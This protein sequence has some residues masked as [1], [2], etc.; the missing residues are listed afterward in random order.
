MQPHVLLKNLAHS[1]PV[2]SPSHSPYPPRKAK[3]AAKMD[4]SPDDFQSYV[5]SL[6]DRKRQSSSAGLLSPTELTTPNS[7]KHS[8]FNDETSTKDIIDFVIARGNAMT[9][10]KR[11]ANK[12]QIQRGGEKVA[13]IMLAR[14]AYRLG[15]T[16]TA[17]VGFGEATLRCYSLNFA[18]ETSETVDG[19]LALR[20]SSSIHRATRRIHATSSEDT[21]FA[22][23]ATFSAM[24]PANATP[25]FI[26]SGVEFQ[27]N[28]RF[29]FLTESPTDEYSRGEELVEEVASDDRGKVYAAVQKLP[30]DTFDV[31]VPIRVYGAAVAYDETNGVDEYP[32]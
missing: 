26:T 32:I 23:R 27:W 16:V 20:S 31:S 30:C 17:V 8:Y 22:Q 15:E 4:S 29:E 1:E 25:E 2:D 14:S 13:T 7:R 24:I 6:V 19:S 12:F 18:L 11:S 9:N 5:E 28:L 10:S 3:T 21:I